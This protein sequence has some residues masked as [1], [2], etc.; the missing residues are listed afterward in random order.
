MI[1]DSVVRLIPG[2]LKKETAIENESFNIKGKKLLE[3]PQYT[4]PDNFK[5]LK[6][7]EILLKGDHKKIEQWR[8]KQ[9][10]EITNKRRLD[11]LDLKDK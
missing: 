2:V 8:L 3:Y 7:P 4:R 10:E 9:A 1:T 6:V 11:L 5:G